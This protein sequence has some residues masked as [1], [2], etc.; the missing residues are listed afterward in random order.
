MKRL[1]LFVC[2]LVVFGNLPASAQTAHIPPG[3]ILYIESTDFGKALSA[4][5]LKKNVP[6][7]IT[8][9]REKASY[10]LES[11]SAAKT[12]QT[13]ERIAKVIVLG[14][15]AGSGKS[16]DASVT[17]TDVDGSVVFAYNSKKSN[18]QSAAEGVAKNLKQ[19]IDKS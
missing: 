15:W 9:D 5:I 2:G 3:A 6:V 14:M 17:I 12:E 19:H 11:V 18:F 7:R 1:I 13:G 8:T 16:F 10:F 4:A